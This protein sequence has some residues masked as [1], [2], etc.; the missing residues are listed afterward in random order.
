MSSNM[1]AGIN[2]GRVL[3]TIGWHDCGYYQ[4]A[5]INRG[6]VL[7]EE[8]RYL[9]V[10]SYW[11][12]SRNHFSW[13]WLALLG[14]LPN[15]GLPIHNLPWQRLL[16]VYSRVGRPCLFLPYNRNRICRNVLWSQLPTC[17]SSLLGIQTG[18]DYK[19]LAYWGVSKGYL[20][21]FYE[22]GIPAVQN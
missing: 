18:K 4:N 10:I 8:I 9:H 13:V 15:S 17:Y 11:S 14:A 19:N 20:I 1:P 22:T 12:S 16:F 5:G 3:L 21:Y 6:R 2:R 7:F